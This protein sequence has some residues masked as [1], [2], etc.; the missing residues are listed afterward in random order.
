MRRFV[1]RAIACTLLLGML[2]V[3]AQAAATPFG[4]TPYF[5]T[6]DTPAGF[7][8][9]TTGCVLN[10]ETF[11]DNALDSFLTI[12]KGEIIYLFESGAASTDSVDG[13]DGVVDGEGFQGRSWYAA[14]QQDIRITFDSAVTSAGLVFTDGAIQSTGISLEAFNGAT[15]LGVINAG[16][17]TDGV[18]TGTTGFGTANPED[19][20]LGF[21][22]MDGITSIKIV[23]AGG[24]GIEIDHIQWHDAT[25]CVPEP[26]A[27]GTALFGLMGLIGFRR[28]RRR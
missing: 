9:A 4:P 10:L 16:D 23:M 1:V 3:A 11:E 28:R 8:A 14:G 17:L 5:K 27:F 25:K 12:D 15:S 13:D 7:H 21:L 18:Y 19:N 20:F 2:P 24:A 22:D 6:G 26:A